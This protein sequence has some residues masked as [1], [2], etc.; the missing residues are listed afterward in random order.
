MRLPGSRHRRTHDETKRTGYPSA[1]VQFAPHLEVAMKSRFDVL[2][3]VVFTVG[4]SV[5][6]TLHSD[7]RAQEQ[8]SPNL[9]TTDHYM[10]L[11][12][13]SDAQISPDGARIIYT[14]QHVNALED[15]WD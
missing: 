4:L 11:E 13:V 10:D 2:A 5:G 12:R 8:R 3:A 7:V 6:L 9:L 15:K 1:G 14:R